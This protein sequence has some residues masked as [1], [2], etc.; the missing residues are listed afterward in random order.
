MTDPDSAT[1][2]WKAHNE[3]FRYEPPDDPLDAWSAEDYDE[4][5]DRTIRRRVQWECQICSQP[6]GTLEK[7][8]RHVSNQHSERLLEQARDRID[9][10]D[11]TT[12][13]EPTPDVD[14]DQATL[15]VATDEEDSFSALSE[16]LAERSELSRRAYENGRDVAHLPD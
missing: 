10:V 15:P 13:A 11:E 6:L 1:D 9:D 4:L 5:W 3:S 7:A 16:R 14:D 2:E 12:D 8:R